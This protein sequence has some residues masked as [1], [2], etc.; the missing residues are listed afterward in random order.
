MPREADYDDTPEVDFLLF[1]A[2]IVDAIE[3]A[4]RWDEFKIENVPPPAP[5]TVQAKTEGVM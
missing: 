3:V 2:G 1:I 5:H 4:G